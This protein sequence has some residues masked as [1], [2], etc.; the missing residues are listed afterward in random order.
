MA[1]KKGDVLEM[2]RELAELTTL[3]EGNVQAFRV[4]AYESAHRAVEAHA[5]D[6]AALDEAALQK[7]DGIGKSTAAKIRELIVSGKVA[8][9]EELRAKHPASV[10]ALMRLPGLGPKAVLKLRAELGIA[11]LDDLRAAIAAHKLRDLRGFGARSEEKLAQ[12]IERLG[13]GGAERR[14][15]IRGRAAGGR[16]H[17]RR[18]GRGPRRRPGS[19]LRQPAPLRRDDWRR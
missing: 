6:I 3:D 1:D 10:T 5:G 18:A 2:L 16:A 12:A 14:T 4:R 8:R 19:L 13:L 17:C 11:S 7:L 15:P 9:L